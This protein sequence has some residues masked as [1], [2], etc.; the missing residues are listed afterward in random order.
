M[1]TSTLHE[2]YT[3]SRL[4]VLQ[5]VSPSQQLRAPWWRAVWSQTA[6]LTKSVERSMSSKTALTS[7]I[8]ILLWITRSISN[9]W[10][11]ELLKTNIWH[12]SKRKRASSFRKRIQTKS[13]IDRA[14]VSRNLHRTLS[15]SQSTTTK[16]LVKTFKP[17]IALTK[18]RIV[19]L[20][21]WGTIKMITGL[22]RIKIV[23]VR[24]KVVERK[25][26]KRVYP[27]KRGTYPRCRQLTTVI[28]WLSWHLTP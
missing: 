8:Q 28:L 27:T 4:L 6:G 1:L 19:R 16:C 24:G 23:K 2:T 5:E 3:V 11:Q 9:Q 13:S 20:K 25:K 12:F 15:I 7:L 26:V 14:S 18:T 10:R 17:K 22:M 21:K